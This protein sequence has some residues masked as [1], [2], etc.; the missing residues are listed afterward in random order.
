MAVGT[1]PKTNP[2]DWAT[3]RPQL[4]FAFDQP[5]SPVING[6]WTRRNEFS[7]WLV[8]KGR[9]KVCVEGET[10]EC[11]PGQWLVVHAKE[12]EQTFSPGTHL[13]SLRVAQSWP[14][15]SALFTEGIQLLGAREHPKLEK[16]ALPLLRYMRTKLPW[17]NQAEDPDPRETFLWKAQITFFEFIDCERRFLAWLKELAIALS[18]KGAAMHLP[19][20]ASARMARVFQAL[21]LVPPGRPFPKEQILR[22]GG[23]SMDRLNQLSLEASGHTLHRYWESRR[24]DWACRMLSTPSVRIK[25]VALEL[26]FK[27]FSYF[28]VW[29]KKHQGQSPRNW[30][31][32][33]HVR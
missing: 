18:G 31:A 14:D 12:I 27:E 6:K 5:V 3:L 1:I 21:D 2:H 29:F 16:L 13:L 15:G 33:R 32:D 20:N 10:C 25:E 4:L 24:V 30:R 8:R 7:A 9:A 26:G 28:S 11:G 23:L 17:Q 22:E 19:E